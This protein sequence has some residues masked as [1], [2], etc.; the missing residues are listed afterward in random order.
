MSQKRAYTVEAPHST[1]DLA[2]RT[3]R[4][5]L[6]EILDWLWSI[7]GFPTTSLEFLVVLSP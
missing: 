4:T 7:G 5:R 1:L 6:I 2:E 3:P